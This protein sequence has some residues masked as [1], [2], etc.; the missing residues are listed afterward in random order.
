MHTVITVAE[1]SDKVGGAA[2]S[3]FKIRSEGKGGGHFKSY[4]LLH[5]LGYCT[6]TQAHGSIRYIESVARNHN[7]HRPMEGQK[8]IITHHKVKHVQGG[9]K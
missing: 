1:T 8:T 5:K 4:L 6:T 2:P 9:S 3:K 7:L